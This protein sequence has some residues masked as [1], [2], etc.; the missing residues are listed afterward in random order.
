MLIDAH[1]H[2]WRYNPADYAWITPRMPMLRRNFLSADL[3]RAAVPAKV[4]GTIAVEA[5]QSLVETRW[6]L[7]LAKRNS[8]IL[9]V[10]GWVPLIAVDVKGHLERFARDPKLRG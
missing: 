4:T 7:Q 3:R 9:G 6:L 5:R 8:L 1:H 2:L 10:V